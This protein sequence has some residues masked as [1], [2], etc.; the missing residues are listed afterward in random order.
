[1]ADYGRLGNCGHFVGS[2]P[3]NAL[4]LIEFDADLPDGLA[5]RPYWRF[6]AQLSEESHRFFAEHLLNNRPQMRA[7][8]ATRKVATLTKQLKIGLCEQVRVN[9]KTATLWSA[10]AWRRFMV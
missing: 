1:L 6:N 4:V 5:T 3:T 8:S 7:S 2:V 9:W 10:A